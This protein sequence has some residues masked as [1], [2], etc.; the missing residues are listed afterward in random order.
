MGI[1]A[2]AAKRKAADLCNRSQA[3]VVS[4]VARPRTGTR[5]ESAFKLGGT[6]KP[7]SQ[8]NS[9]T[10][11][12]MRHTMCRHASQAATFAEIYPLCFDAR[13]ACSADLNKCKY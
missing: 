5:T 12:R 4:G 7:D 8:A 2:N 3:T 6:R 11:R 1:V 9:A 13:V 10:G